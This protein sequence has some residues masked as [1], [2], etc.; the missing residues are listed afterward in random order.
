MWLPSPELAPW[1]GGLIDEA[2]GFP[3]ATHDDQVDALSQALNRLVLQQLLAGTD[4]SQ[5]EEYDAM[6]ARGLYAS[7]V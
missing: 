4:L 1:V 5:P 6:D 2:A 3:N 7:P